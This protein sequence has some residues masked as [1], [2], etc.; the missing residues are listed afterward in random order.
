MLNRYPVTS[1]SSFDVS[2]LEED[3]E[4][5]QA[6]I[7]GMKEEIKKAKSRDSLLGPLM[8]STYKYRQ[9]FIRCEITPVSTVIDKFPALVEPSMVSPKGL[10]LL[11]MHVCVDRARNG[12]DI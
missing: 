2:S 9:D 11:C 7:K 3:A 10:L 12:F 6:H 8:K 1:V 4:S 5:L